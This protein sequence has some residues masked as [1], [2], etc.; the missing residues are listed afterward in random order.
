MFRDAGGL[1]LIGEDPRASRV[2]APAIA[3]ARSRAI[4]RTCTCSVRSDELKT[5][6]NREIGRASCRERVWISGGGDLFDRKDGAKDCCDHSSWDHIVLDR[7]E[8][9]QDGSIIMLYCGVMC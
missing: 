6:G 1:G 9:T 8:C 2:R 3:R 4:G 5:A 7:D